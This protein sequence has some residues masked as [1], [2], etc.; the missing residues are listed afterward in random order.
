MCE[1]LLMD[2]LAIRAD[3]I[4]PQASE[5]FSARLRQMGVAQPNPTFSPSS[6]ADPILSAAPSY[7]TYP[8]PGQNTTLTALEARRRLQEQAE[9]EFANTG[10][11]GDRGRQF[12]D[13]STIREML[14]LREKGVA[15]TEIEARLRLQKG[16]VQRLGPKALLRPAT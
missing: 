13:I 8:S 14:L 7:P 3:S 16:L 6:T 4:D 12:L 1:R 2:Y 15:D 11:S 10:K 9:A 5:A